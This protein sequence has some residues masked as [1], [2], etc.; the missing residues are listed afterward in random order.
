MQQTKLCVEGPKGSTTTPGKIRGLRRPLQRDF[1]TFQSLQTSSPLRECRPVETEAKKE[2]Y[3]DGAS[4]RLSFQ[5]R[6]L[7]RRKRHRRS[8]VIQL[9]PFPIMFMPF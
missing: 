6:Q 7:F 3:Y 2:V 5:L 9:E 8:N 1:L 4:T